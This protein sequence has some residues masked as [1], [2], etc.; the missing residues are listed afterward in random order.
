MMDRAKGAMEATLEDIERMKAE[1]AERASR[2]KPVVRGGEHIDGAKPRSFDSAIE[3]AL[4]R[5]LGN[6]DDGAKGEDD[7]DR[8][9]GR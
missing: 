9:R 7:A 3:E 8:E 6:T 5:G 1:E 4:R 2:R